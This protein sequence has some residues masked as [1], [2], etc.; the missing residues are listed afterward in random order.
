MNARIRKLVGGVGLLVFIGG[1]I[2]AATAIADHLPE[3]GAIKF[4][5]YAVVGL[6]WGVPVLPLISWMNRGRL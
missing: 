4:I 6:I 1:Y 2:W 5:Y 3:H